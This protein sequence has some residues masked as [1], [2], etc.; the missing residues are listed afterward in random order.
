MISSL[1]C[2]QCK[3]F[4]ARGPNCPMCKIKL[5]QFIQE[6]A[7]KTYR[8]SLTIRD[9]RAATAELIESDTLMELYS[10]LN[11]VTVKLMTVELENKDDEISLLR[12]DIPF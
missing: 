3:R 11:M 2:K 12:D 4:Y 10:K 8:Y 5:G 9:N 7:D 6:E 1:Y